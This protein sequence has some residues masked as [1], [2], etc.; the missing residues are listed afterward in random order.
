M[1]ILLIGQAAF[2]QDVFTKLREAGQEVV[3]VAAPAQSLS[4]RPDSP[5]KSMMTKSRPVKSSCAR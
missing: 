2:G 4:G 5:S 3:A 1:R